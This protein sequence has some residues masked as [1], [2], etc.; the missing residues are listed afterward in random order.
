MQGDAM[1]D[2]SYTD[3]STGLHDKVIQ[4]HST[5]ACIAPLPGP[6]VQR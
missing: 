6:A 1:N 5:R 3:R 2:D 4:V